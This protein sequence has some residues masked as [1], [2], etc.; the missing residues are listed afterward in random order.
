MTIAIF[1]KRN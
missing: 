1:F